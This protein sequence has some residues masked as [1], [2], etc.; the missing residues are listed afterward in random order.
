MRFF[1]FLAITI[2]F[3]YCTNK[4]KRLSK[5]EDKFKDYVPVDS[6]IQYFLSDSFFFVA[7]FNQV[8]ADSFVKKWYS[9]VLFNL[10]DQRFF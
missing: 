2:F 7:G 4:E 5:V 9:E 6:N 10:R 1:L 3:S 8:N